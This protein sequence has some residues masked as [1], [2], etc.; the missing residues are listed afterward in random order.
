MT[1]IKFFF[2]RYLLWIGFLFYL[3][4]A[5]FIKNPLQDVH[6]FESAGFYL[7]QKIDIYFIDQT[8]G[9]YPFFP[10]LI[11]PYALAHLVVLRFPILAFSF[12]I[13][14]IFIPTIFALGILIEKISLLQGITKKTALKRKILFCLNPV[15]FF[16]VV[17]HGQAD[18]LLL[19]FYFLSFYLLLN[20]KGYLKI[21]SSG[22]SFG[23]SVLTKTWSIVFFP[24]FLLKIRSLKLLLLHLISASSS[25]F[26]ICYIYT[27]F[28][29]SSFRQVLNA[30]LGHPAVFGQ[31]S[32]SP[33]FWGIAA[34]L[35]LTHQITKNSNIQVFTLHFST[36]STFIL[37]GVFLLLYLIIF[38]KK[39]NFLRASLILVL[40]FYVITPSWGTQY[41]FWILPFLFLENIVYGFAY[42]LIATPYLFLSYLSAITPGEIYMNLSRIFSLFPWIF[43]LA[44]FCQL[45]KNVIQNKK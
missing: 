45:I 15:V 31:H 33:S 14:L 21:V 18:V 36:L 40:G 29:N 23:L 35:N 25:I 32:G 16:T 30:V 43:S 10:F 12:L 28:V 1:G 39:T 34:V 13:K 20:D 26:I 27:R 4:F 17:Y 37:A 7:T 3:L 5:F 9:T 8:H 6:L 44:V 11:F 24:L 22:I 41:T 42:S 19:F 38:F 2:N